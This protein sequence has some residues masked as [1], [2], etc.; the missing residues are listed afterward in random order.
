MTSGHKQRERLRHRFP[1]TNVDSPE[2]GQ[3]QQHRDGKFG[4]DILNMFVEL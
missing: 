4:G 1:Q 3:R 2:G